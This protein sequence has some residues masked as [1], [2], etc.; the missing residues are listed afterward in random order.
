MLD[1]LSQFFTNETV[2]EQAWEAT[3][4]AVSYGVD[5]YMPEAKSLLTA[6]AVVVGGAVVIGGAREAHRR[7][8]LHVPTRENPNPF[9]KKPAPHSAKISTTG[10][11]DSTPKSGPSSSHDEPAH[12]TRSH[13]RHE[14]EHA[15]REKSRS[16][17][18]SPSRRG[19]TDQ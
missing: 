16:R 13:D 17:S 19:N 2:R 9:A 4:G 11:A 15:D 18:P 12:H 10:E 8:H 5:N 3:K 7:G 1:A 6:A 14:D